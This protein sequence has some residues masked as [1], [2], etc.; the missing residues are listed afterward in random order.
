[1]SQNLTPT[2]LKYLAEKF[3]LVNGSK[4]PVKGSVKIYGARKLEI[5]HGASISPKPKGSASS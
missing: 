2:L 3:Q 5:V 1:M 4:E